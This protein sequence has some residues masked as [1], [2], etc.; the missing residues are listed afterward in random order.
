MFCA[1]LQQS[2]PLRVNTP[3]PKQWVFINVKLAQQ[4][5]LEVRQSF[6]QDADG[7]LFMHQRQMML[8]V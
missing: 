2:A 8:F 1:M 4:N 6:I 5:Y 7:H 3:T